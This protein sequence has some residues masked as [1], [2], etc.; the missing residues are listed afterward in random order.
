MLPQFT[1]ETGSNVQERSSKKKEGVQHSYLHDM[2]LKLRD[3]EIIDG[4]G[5]K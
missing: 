3:P 1:L 5:L 4:T 2:R